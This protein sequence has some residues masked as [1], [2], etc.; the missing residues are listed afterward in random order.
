MED[1]SRQAPHADEFQQRLKSL[2]YL[3]NPLEKFFIG[4]AHGPA[5]VFVANL[6][7]A[8]KVGVLGG[9][10]L[11][12]ATAAGMVL[13]APETLPR[14]GEL[15]KLAAYFSII[16]SGFF[17]ALELVICLAV[18]LL[19]RTFRR[20][21]TRTGMIALYSAAFAGL[22]VLLYGTLWWW[23]QGSNARL[24]SLESAW[25][26]LVVV[27]VA[28]AAAFLT[29]VGVG[30]LLALL[31]G[32]DLGA[33]GK[34]R[35]TKLY[36]LI[37]VTG[38]IIFTGYRLATSVTP[39]EKPAPYDK[40]PSDLSVTLVA[41]DGASLSFFEHLSASGDLPVLS[42]LAAGGYVA[43]LGEPRVLVNPAIWT[44]VATGV[45][46]AKHG[47]TAFSGQQIPGLGLY[48][49]E[50][51]GFGLYDALLR[52]LPVVGLSRRAPLERRSLAFPALWDIIATKGELSG[53]VNWWGSWPAANFHGFL[54]TDRMYPKLQVAH[55]RGEAAGFEREIYPEALFRK[56][57]G[58]ELDGVK[59]SEEPMRAAEDIDRFAVTALLSGLEDYDSITLSAVYLPG[60]DIYT[61]SLEDKS[62][63]AA[64]SLAERARTVAG[65]GEYWRFLDSLLAPVVSAAGPSHVVV[66]VGDPGMLKGPARRTG[67]RAERGF[68]IFSGGPA[69]VGRG[70][71]ELQVVDIAP[72]LLY[73]L[74]FPVSEEM[75]G[76]VPEEVFSAEFQANRP[77]ETIETYGR[78]RITP[79][80]FYSVDSQLVERLRSLGYL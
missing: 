79:G 1:K 35:A 26:F 76:R 31:G 49:T 55:L 11:G 14:A 48:V 22:S 67:R 15:F 68:V 12:M 71:G 20:L 42:T 18:T 40:R 65:A 17:T 54:V 24:L 7:I 62:A 60:L 41:I 36:V 34:G 38:L 77:P 33:R 27:I 74:G 50:T 56:L 29:R 4:G 69:A 70:D 44:S 19:G 37:L 8:L 47:V 30:S 75:D 66:V 16:Y 45:T 51:T 6:K 52:A 58:Y 25:A 32:A 21:F 28:G 53:V 23:A 10:F 39:P 5:G 13:L 59:L 57:E 46:P 72:A 3:D 73:L 43:A 9:V 63:E 64:A 78:V 80:S 2:G 61:N